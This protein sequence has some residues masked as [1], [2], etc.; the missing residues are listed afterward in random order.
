M[1][2]RRRKLL[3]YGG[4]TI[5]QSLQLWLDAAD[6][7]TIISSGGSVSQWNDKSGKGNNV[8]QGTGS[9]QPTTGATQNGKNVLSFDGGDTLNFPSGL[10]TIPNGANTVFAVSKRATEDG[11][12]DGIL[13][14]NESG[15]ERYLLG[16]GAPSGRYYFSS[17][18]A[19]GSGVTQDSA[20]ANT[21]FKVVYGRR[22][23]TTLAIS[24][25]GATESTNAN[26]ADEPGINGGFIG[27]SASA[28]MTGQI[29]EI[30]IY[31]R[32]LSASER[33]VVIKYLGS[34]WG[35]TVA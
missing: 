27:G 11:T 24:Q 4:L 12:A 22:S 34:K 17:R 5:R 26:G 35:I 32:S 9:A 13:C 20:G 21:N 15:V 30:L 33:S 8:T 23:G 19:I 29:A 18:N 3:A 1:S 16:Y 2:R 25:N 7:S 31:N 6:T 28:N 14:F 10:F